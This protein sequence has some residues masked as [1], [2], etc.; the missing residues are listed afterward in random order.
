ME[1]G[2]EVTEPPA[3]VSQGRGVRLRHLG[4]CGA[5]CPGQR[6]WQK[7]SLRNEWEEN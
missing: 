6:R 5:S 4:P 3:L 7:A 2:G 1:E